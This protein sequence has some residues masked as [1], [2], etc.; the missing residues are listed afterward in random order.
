MLNKSSLF[1][2]GFRPFFILASITALINPAL[3]ASNL[4]KG[5]ELPI[6][7]SPLFWHGHEMLFGYT[8]A[9]IAG[10]ILTASA[11][12]TGTIPYKGNSLIILSSLWIIERVIYLFDCMPLTT[13]ILT[14]IFYPALLLLLFF[15]IKDH[16]K[17]RNVFIPLL[18]LIFLS[19]LSH[20]YGHLFSVE[21]FEILGLNTGIS[22]ITLLLF[23]IAG[24]VIPFFTRNKIGTNIDIPKFVHM[25][26]LLSLSL[27]CLPIENQT[28]LTTILTVAFISNLYRNFLMF[29]KDVL[30]VPMLWVLHSGLLFLTFSLIV[31]LIS[32]YI[33]EINDNREVIHLTVVGGLGLISLGIMTRVSLGHTGRIIKASK[34]TI[35]AYISIFIA[36][37]LRA[38]VPYFFPDYYDIGVYIA[39]KFWSLAFILFLFIYGK[40][41][42]TER[43]DGK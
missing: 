17:Q 15:K 2:I 42:F 22:L 10:F 24:R 33:P 18:T 34:M 21:Y 26:S 28:Y 36:A 4:L 25:A 8:S 3:W 37:V 29:R 9:L 13:L 5:F 39:S 32:L 41:L 30:K 1:S 6:Y 31:R 19:S 23:L 40:I 43:P 7:V 12:W 38:F 11:N 14:H 27:L 20:S 35:V 16:S